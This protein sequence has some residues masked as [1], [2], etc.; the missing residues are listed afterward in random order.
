MS[1]LDA[2]RG[3]ISGLEAA[4]EDVRGEVKALDRRREELDRQ[5]AAL[6]RQHAE[7]SAA[8]RVMERLSSRTDRPS[9]TGDLVT[10]VPLTPRILNAIVDAG[11]ATRPDLL[12]RFSPDVNANTV[13][14]AVRRLVRRGSIRRD[15]RRLV[16]VTGSVEP[17]FADLPAG[18]VASDSGAV[19]PRDG[20]APVVPEVSGGPAG[21]HAADSLPEDRSGE[22]VPVVG[23]PTVDADKAVPLTVRVLEAV[24]ASVACTRRALLQHFSAQGVREASVDNA[25]AGLRRQGKL[26]RRAG[27]VLAVPGPD[28]S[29]APSGAV[30]ADP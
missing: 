10:E 3:P 6:E 23:T 7:L 2:A 20:L 26:E 28:V 15:G 25:V 19:Q 30:S 29:S 13:D 16:P 5:R 11:V 14:S 8:V 9:R 27:G 12:R 24:A 1:D 4:L 22:R 17:G 18:V 21:V